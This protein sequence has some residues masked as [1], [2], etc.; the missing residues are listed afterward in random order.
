M[1]TLNYIIGKEVVSMLEDNDFSEF[2]EYVNNENSDCLHQKKF[3]TEKEMQQFVAGLEAGGYENYSI[4]KEN[5]MM[6]LDKDLNA[7]NS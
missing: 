6:E 2:I 7:R 1:A 4:L 3:D 5:E